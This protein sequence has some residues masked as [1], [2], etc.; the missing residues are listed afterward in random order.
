MTLVI[1]LEKILI[2]NFNYAQLSQ[3]YLQDFDVR[4]FL[5]K[6]KDRMFWKE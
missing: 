2:I 6:L 3:R 5:V 1:F 4:N